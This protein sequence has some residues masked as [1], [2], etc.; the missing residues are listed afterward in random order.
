MGGDC[1][2][3]FV[4]ETTTS[5]V[6]T[7]SLDLDFDRERDLRCGRSLGTWRNWEVI[8]GMAKTC[9]KGGVVGETGAGKE[10]SQTWLQTL[11][12]GSDGYV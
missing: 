1:G 4:G 7:T 9:M 3:S 6:V 12:M 11:D 10:E 8:V 2:L 5:A